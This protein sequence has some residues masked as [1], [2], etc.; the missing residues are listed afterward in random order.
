MRKE[1][2]FTTPPGAAGFTCVWHNYKNNAKNRGIVFA[3]TKEELRALTQQN[4]SYCGTIPCQ[5]SKV[6]G[7]KISQRVLDH[8]IY[9][10]NGV[11]RIDSSIGYFVE[12]LVTCCVTCN[13]MK[14]ALGVAEFLAHIVKIY[15]YQNKYKNL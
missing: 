10:Y 9:I 12:N 13:K 5:V 14:M 4:C 7:P 8:S 2:K 15:S 1:R 3:V 6:I 11:D